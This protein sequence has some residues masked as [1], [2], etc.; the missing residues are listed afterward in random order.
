MKKAY[1]KA[2]KE[3]LEGAI[4]LPENVFID[5]IFIQNE[6][7]LKGWGEI[8]IVLRGDG[9][10]DECLR[11]REGEKL[12]QVEVVFKQGNYYFCERIELFKN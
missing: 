11:R 4:R 7:K 9:L 5:D 2:S 1:V 8:T 6:D 12:Q 3:V 10:P